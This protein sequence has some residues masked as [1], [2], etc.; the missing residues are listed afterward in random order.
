MPDFQIT[1]EERTSTGRRPNK[2]LRAEGRVPANLYGAGKGNRNLSLP[3]NELVQLM[4]DEGFFSSLLTLNGINEDQ[5][6]LVREV[7]MH[8]Y[9]PKP[10]HV[11]M[12]RI[13]ADEMLTVEVPLHLMNEEQAPGVLQGG[14]LSQLINEIQVVCLPRNIPDHLEVDVGAMDI[15][16]TL[17]LSDITAPPGVEIPYD[18]DSDQGV[19]NITGAAAAEGAE[20]G[21]EAG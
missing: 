2:R 19:A 8:P 20:E 1:A 7:Q 13:K 21:E 6:V 16:D 5:E 10:I 17:F 15:G 12:Q 4:E 3:E 18:E 14:T 11:D 9:K